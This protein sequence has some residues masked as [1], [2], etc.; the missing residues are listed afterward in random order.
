MKCK[1]ANYR[2]YK[3]SYSLQKIKQFYTILQLKAK[4]Q[5]FRF[6]ISYEGNL[7]LPLN[8]AKF[9]SDK[10]NF[11]PPQRKEREERLDTIYLCNLINNLLKFQSLNLIFC[12]MLI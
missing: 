9:A 1:F 11:M 2:N 5:N 7:Q 4:L 12:N 3:G 6:F 8:F 10:E